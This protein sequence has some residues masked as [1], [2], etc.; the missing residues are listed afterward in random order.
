MK[1]CRGE[2]LKEKKAY[3]P[4]YSG[5]TH[6]HQQTWPMIQSGVDFTKL[7]RLPAPARKVPPSDTICVGKPAPHDPVFAFGSSGEYYPSSDR[8]AAHPAIRSLGGDNAAPVA[9]M[10]VTA[11]PGIKPSPPSCTANDL[12]YAFGSSGE[13]SSSHGVAPPRPAGPSGSS[14]SHSK[15]DRSF[16]QAHRAGLSAP[17]VPEVNPHVNQLGNN[18]PQAAGTVNHNTNNAFQRAISPADSGYSTITPSISPVPSKTP[19]PQSAQNSNFG[20]NP[21][22]ANNP[23]IQYPL[24]QAHLA[25]GEGWFQDLAAV[26]AQPEIPAQEEIIAAPQMVHVQPEVYTQQELPVKTEV[27]ALPKPRRGRPPG[28]GGRYKQR[29]KKGDNPAVAGGNNV[30]KTK[31]AKRPAAAGSK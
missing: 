6:D 21:T 14:Y 22:F 28:T 15:S 30:P 9:P 7:P 4:W 1:K 24:S 5:S 2:E 16:A 8:P 25:P 13:N 11:S 17:A 29:A 27:P 18:W 31:R 20:I 10:C 19:R 23:Q 12:V 3:E 26:M